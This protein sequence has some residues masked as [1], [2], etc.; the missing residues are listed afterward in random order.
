MHDKDS[1]RMI[2]CTVVDTN[3]NT[4]GIVEDTDMTGNLLIIRGSVD[5]REYSVPKNSVVNI[6][7][8][9][10]K[11]AIQMTADDFIKYAKAY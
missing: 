3:D 5:S 11:I 10:N 7:R 6:D 2:G 4:L 8:S 1:E 9:S